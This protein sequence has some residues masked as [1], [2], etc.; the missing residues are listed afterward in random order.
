MKHEFFGYE[1]AGV[2]LHAAID[3]Q[4]LNNNIHNSTLGAWFDWQAQ[5]L[6]VSGNLFYEN[7]RDLMIEVTHG[8]YK[9]DNNIFASNYNFDNVAQGG[10]YIHNLCC[11][12][13][14]RIDCRDRSTPYHFPH[15]T[16]VAGSVIVYGGDDRLYHNI[17]VGGTEDTGEESRYGTEGYDGHPSSWKEYLDIIVSKG[18]TDHE[19][20]QETLDAVY[21]NGNAYLKEAPA[22]VQEKQNFK[23]S[24]DPNVKIV[25]T[26]EGTYLEMDIEEG[27]LEIPTEIICTETLGMPR[28]TE[29]PFDDPEGNSIIFDRDYFGNKRSVKPTPGPIEG[30]KAG[31]NRI[32][33]WEA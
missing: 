11:G 33:V 29:A 19:K 14:R 21:I 20:F 24:A 30:L 5:G 18:N 22:Y 4:L 2:K 17:F 9:V 32:C 15:S 25:E 26:A 6:R 7:D 13:M 8:P 23:S 3:V 1:I 16:E 12:T 10:A 27:V 28:I 31:H